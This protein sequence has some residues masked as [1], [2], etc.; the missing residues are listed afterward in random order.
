MASIRFR[1]SVDGNNWQDAHPIYK[2]LKIKYKQESK[3]AFFREE[4][5]G[6]VK[7]VQDD[8]D[9]ILAAPFD[10][11]YMVQIYISTIDSEGFGEDKD[12]LTK[13]TRTKCEIDIDNKILETKLEIIDQYEKILEAMDKE[14]DLLALGAIA[15]SISLYKRPVLQCYIPG[16]KIV[17]SYING[18]YWESECDPISDTGI[19]YRDYA[20]AGIDTP[21]IDYAWK[22]NSSRATINNTAQDFYKSGNEH[23]SYDEQLKYVWPEG[24]SHP[25][26]YYKIG[27][28]TQW[29]KATYIDYYETYN[30]NCELWATSKRYVRLQRNYKRHLTFRLLCDNKDDAKIQGEDSGTAFTGIL[31]KNNEAFGNTM[32]YRYAIRINP[33]SY[34]VVPII[35]IYCSSEKG[36]FG[37]RQ[38][39]QFYRYPAIASSVGYTTAWPA[40]KSTWGDAGIWFNYSVITDIVDQKYRNK[41]TIRDA[42]SLGNCIRAL[43]KEVAPKLKF[44]DN[45]NY[46]KF[47]FTYSFFNDLKLYLTQKSNALKG[48][49]DMPAQKMPITLKK[50]FDMLK[51]C[52]KV[53]WYIE[54]NKLRLEHISYFS[55]GEDYYSSVPIDL[56]NLYDTRTQKPWSFGKNNYEFESEDMPER[57]Q[58]AWSD[59]SSEPFEGKPLEVLSN[60][61]K[62]GQVDEVSVNGFTSDIDMMISTPGNFSQDGIAILVANTLGFVPYAS[63]KMVY[64]DFYPSGNEHEVTEIYSVQN[65]FLSF[66]NLIPSYY[67]GDLPGSKVNINGIDYDIVNDY[68]SGTKIKAAVKRAKKQKLKC[69][70]NLLFNPY[71]LYKTEMGIGQLKEATYDL[72]SE[73]A[74]LTILHDTES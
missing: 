8:F 31:V 33:N 1:L 49:Y 64:E 9:R 55:N 61:V 14:Y 59:D 13:F 50:L 74:E 37:Q 62:K 40:S 6:K 52:F 23:I 36:R 18:V 15:D 35:N 25:D 68:L 47:F 54:N 4:L 27:P 73:V 46:S 20:F 58:F 19:L 3:E 43:L 41:V 69:P 44:E 39:G 72:S 21:S 28:P 56:T 63:V 24:A 65:G 66:A 2:E 45:T 71:K 53:Y 32:N 48:N 34:G 5:D 11:V 57:I 30:F 16:E 22:G 70:I 42:Y 60:Y 38:P 26:L 10:T 17:S 29:C 7:F 51:N 67:G 12:L